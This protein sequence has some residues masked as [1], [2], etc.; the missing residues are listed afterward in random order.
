MTLPHWGP[1]PAADAA[2]DTLSHAFQG[3]SAEGWTSLFT[4]AVAMTGYTLFSEY[5]WQV[6]RRPGMS[7]AG[8][9]KSGAP[10]QLSRTHQ[11]VHPANAKG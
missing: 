1:T 8:Q 11:A 6:G 4:L 5:S 7:W 2:D 9:A 10:G 3:L